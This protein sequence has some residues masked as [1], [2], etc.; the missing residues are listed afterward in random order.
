MS[1]YT[2]KLETRNLMTA[3]KL[4]EAEQSTIDFVPNPKKNGSLFFT[5]GS[6]TGYIAP[7]LLNEID[8]APIED[9]VYVETRKE[10]SANWVPCLML[11][12]AKRRVGAELLNK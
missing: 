9:M 8:T 12:K 7:S 3:A 11:R 2:T 6:K 1:Q 4:V 5:C 10:D